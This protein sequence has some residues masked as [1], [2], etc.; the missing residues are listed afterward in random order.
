MLQEL[1]R[2]SA[3]VHANAPENARLERRSGAGLLK[4]G[5]Q[6][7]LQCLKDHRHLPH[8]WLVAVPHEGTQQL[9]EHAGRSAPVRVDVCSGTFAK[10]SVTFSQFLVAAGFAVMSFS[11][12]VE[13]DFVWGS[14][15]SDKRATG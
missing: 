3:G 5:S 9:A 11:F 13:S 8:C 7:F 6:V 15:S 14:I 10:A 2:Q 4:N 12:H 1:I